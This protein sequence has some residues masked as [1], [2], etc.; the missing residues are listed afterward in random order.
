[1]N[2]LFTQ[3]QIENAIKIYDDS[4]E[5]LIKR[6]A[7][8]SVIIPVYNCKRY[9]SIAIESVRMQSW[10]NIELIIIDDASDDGTTELLKKV[11]D[12]RAAEVKLIFRLKNGGPA[13]ALNDGIRESKGDYIKWL[14]ADDVLYPNGIQDMM[15][16]GVEDHKEKSKN[17]I[18]YS[19]YDIIDDRGGIICEFIEP[20]RNGWSQVAQA[21]ELWKHFYGNGS[22][23]L[24]H[25][26]VFKKCGLFDEN[27]KHSED[28]EF[29]LR[30]T[31]LFGVEMIRVPTKTIKY[32]RHPDQL[33]NTV[34]GSLDAT[35]KESIKQRQLQL[36]V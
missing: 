16:F 11:M 10:R 9:V 30:A 21:D 1:M 8:V 22:S 32:R 14:S 4:G 33:T 19:D 29:W 18:F 27:L 36:Q 7:L 28:Y 35:I 5:R 23:S 13:A 3:D 34:G 17:A 12:A 15:L 6:Q 20:D 31:I 26:N 25:K 24:I 2:P